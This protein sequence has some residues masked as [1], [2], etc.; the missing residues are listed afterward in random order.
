MG[1]DNLT[2]VL[3]KTP[4]YGAHVVAGARM[5]E[6]G[7]WTMPLQY[8]GILAEHQAVRQAAGLFDVSHM[9]EFEVTGPNAGVFLQGLVP[10]DVLALKPR[11]ALYTQ[12]TRPDGGTVDDLLI[13]RVEAGYWLVVNAA[14]I[15]KDWDWLHEH[16]IDG[17]SL[18][19][20][21][22][23]WALLALQGPKAEAILTALWA[24][25]MTPAS[26]QSFYWM[27]GSL[28]GIPVRVGR[29]GYTGEDGFEI[30][31]RVAAAPDVWNALLE[32]GKGHGLQLAGLGARDTLRLEAGLP[33]YGHELQDGI[34][35]VE[36]G[37]GWSVKQKPEPYLGS[38]VLQSQKKGGAS[39]RVVGLRLEGPGIAR[40]GY[41]VWFGD[42]EVGQVL[43][44][45]FSPTLGGPIATAL[46]WGDG[47]TAT[48]LDV[49]IRRQ[50]CLARVVSLP[51]YRRSK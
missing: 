51:F 30:F 38:E 12:F 41:P 3:A 36:A 14:N 16:R 35:P 45:T 6:F 21:S 33:L 13:Y 11:Q 24:G 8:T 48:H 18:R 29:T 4:L 49:Q 5:V 39:R 23:E 46:V 26:L 34:T 43:S 22:E 25:D 44:G 7:G 31:C 19:D 15:R 10:N 27:D 2:T 42:K 17:V 37:L 32:A 28:S 9:G 1:Q 20:C 50:R 47:S 40:E